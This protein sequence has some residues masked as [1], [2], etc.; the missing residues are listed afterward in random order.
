M[1]LLSLRVRNDPINLSPNLLQILS[2]NLCILELPPGRRLLHKSLQQ[3]LL[4]QQR[5]QSMSQLRIRVN[6]G[7]IERQCGGRGC[8]GTRVRFA[9]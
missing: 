3:R 2:Q 4:L 9:R 1:G 8:R 5:L 6:R 7:F